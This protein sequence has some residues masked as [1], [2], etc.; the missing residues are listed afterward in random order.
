MKWPIFWSFKKRPI[1]WSKTPHG[2]IYGLSS[3]KK[4]IRTCT[5]RHC[6]KPVPLQQQMAPLPALRTDDVGAFRHCSTDLFGPM[7]AKHS[8]EH[9]ECPHPKNSNP[10]WVNLLDKVTSRFIFEA[11][12][13]LRSHRYPQQ[14]YITEIWSITRFYIASY[15]ALSCCIPCLQPFL[16]K[17]CSKMIV[18]QNYLT[19]SI[20]F[21]RRRK[22]GTAS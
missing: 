9:A 20:A 13:P 19:I 3:R 4:I 15:I 2:L 18:W 8:C 16:S 21:K 22:N 12:L 11:N 7:L 14:N 17:M 5:K 6:T 10:S 1:F